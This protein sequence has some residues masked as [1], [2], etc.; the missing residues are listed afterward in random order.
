MIRFGLKDTCAGS[1][2]M[3]RR[4]GSRCRKVRKGWRDKRGAVGSA[5]VVGWIE[6]F[7]ARGTKA[8]QPFVEISEPLQRQK[9]H[10]SLYICVV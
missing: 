8:C 9:R 1:G 7:G 3:R 4:G 6:E 5:F 2:G 10:R